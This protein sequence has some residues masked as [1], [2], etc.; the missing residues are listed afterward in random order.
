LKLTEADID[1]L[2]RQTF[3]DRRLS[4][5]ERRALAQLVENPPELRLRVRRRSFEVAKSFAHD[6]DFPI[7]LDWLEEVQKALT[8]PTPSTRSPNTTSSPTDDEAFFAPREDI[9]RRI[10]F[11]L[12]NLTTRADLAVFT[13]TDDR[14]SSAILAAHR[15]GIAIRIVSDNDKANDPGSDIERL[16][17]A[18]LAVRIDRTAV[19]MHHKFAV[20]DNRL[21]I[22]GSYNWTRSAADDNHENL[23]FH[24][25]PRLIEAFAA[26]FQ[27]CWDLAEPF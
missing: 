26:E 7:V 22:N 3:D 27:H 13:I 1:H 23:V 18:G 14:V 15:R 17:R 25:A 6:V 20:L 10:V 4:R 12:N 11:A 8:E 9:P 21:L 16:A 19:H 2:L 5:G 24:R